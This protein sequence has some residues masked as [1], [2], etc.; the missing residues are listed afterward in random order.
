MGA[1]GVC[2]SVGV[3]VVCLAATNGV[4]AASVFSSGVPS[5]KE[6][7]RGGSVKSGEKIKLVFGLTRKQESL[8]RYADSVS[9]PKSKLYG[10]HLSVKQIARRYGASDATQ[11]QVLSFLHKQGLKP[12]LHGHGSS[13]AVTLTVDNAERMFKTELA[14]YRLRR[15][16]EKFIAPRNSPHLPQELRGYVTEV[17]GLSTRK[18]NDRKADVDA[19]PTAGVAAP[20]IAG[21]AP[22]GCPAGQAVGSLTPNQIS[23]LYGISQLQAQGFQGQGMRLAVLEMDTGVNQSDI[24]T[25]TSC[26]G[27]P[28]QNIKQFGIGGT[29][30]PG[31][32]AQW[33]DESTL[34]VEV[35]LTVA[36]QLD[37]LYLVSSTDSEAGFADLVNGALDSSTYG[38]GETP[39][40]L[41][42]SW[43]ACEPAMTTQQ[44]SLVE[45]ALET[46]SAAGVSVLFATGDY[47][48][49]NCFSAPG[50]LIQ[51]LAMWYPATSANATAVGGTQFNISGSS[52]TEVAW[53]SLPA[54]NAGGGWQSLTFS[55]PR[56]QQGNGVSIPMR[57]VPVVAFLGG[58][59]WYTIYLTPPGGTGS[60]TPVGG[61]SAA[62]PLFAAGIALVN[63]YSQSKGG[64]LVGNPN[65]LLYTLQGNAALS[66]VTSGSNDLFSLGCCTA[67]TGYDQATGLGSVNLPALAQ[68]VAT[69][70]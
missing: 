70:K 28:Q 39:Q 40:I 27:L 62:T 33:G 16:G 65:Q 14:R 45:Q 44:I 18:V 41:S 36:P 34:D 22:S 49:S 7:K 58:S 20:T 6:A 54:Q 66:D 5:A 32:S 57:S 12:R 3:A 8:S 67:S 47:G 42:V 30:A 15:D 46:A 13:L 50:T 55:K 59:P 23:G 63:Q 24:D 38:G 31:P 21:N 25:F 52:S 35:A 53:N 61:T 9:N 37:D 69:G 19:N 10:K 56:W 48:S 17:L 11:D 29:A 64:G 51:Q 60:Y 2:V 43:G 68:T 1:R 26:F 4:Q